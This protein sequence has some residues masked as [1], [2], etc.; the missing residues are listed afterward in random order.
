M[1][2]DGAWRFVPDRTPGVFSM[3]NSWWIILHYVIYY[4]IFVFSISDR[5][6]KLEL[7]VVYSR[8]ELSLEIVLQ[9]VVLLYTVTNLHIPTS[10]KFSYSRSTHQTP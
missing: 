2:V 9:L 5:N 1:V 4:S 8:T 3:Y 6:E 10:R 7:V